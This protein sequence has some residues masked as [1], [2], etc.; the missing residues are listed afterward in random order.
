L[1]RIEIKLSKTK[2]AVTGNGPDVINVHRKFV[3]TTLKNCCCYCFKVNADLN[4]LLAILKAIPK[5]FSNELNCANRKFKNSTKTPLDNIS[6][7][8]SIVTNL[9]QSSL[10]TWTNCFTSIQLLLTCNKQGDQ[11]SLRKKLPKM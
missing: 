8:F 5:T 10:S 6:T 3:E 1:T 9:D 11:M 2:K 7:L 4:R